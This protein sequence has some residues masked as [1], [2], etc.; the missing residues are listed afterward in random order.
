MSL[1]KKSVLL[2][3]LILAADQALKIWVKTHMALGE[4]ISLFSDRAFIHFTENPG[5]AFGIELDF[6]GSAGKLLLTLFRVAF[7]GVLVWF[8]WK[9]IRRKASTGFVLGLSAMCAGAMGNL[10]DCFFY[11]PVFSVST[12]TQVA[13]LFP[14]G[15]GYEAFGFGR[16]VDMLYF[17]I[18]QGTYP[19]W[20]PFN[21]GERFIFFRPIFNLADAAITCSVFYLLIFQRSLFSKDEAK[22]LQQGA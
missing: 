8:T 21:A 13:Q 6:L 7:I 2:A 18:I 16:V 9:Q 5:M 14:A 3:V 1:L 17:P 10:I 11:G 12:Y 20:F 22:E 4:S 15:G 19:S